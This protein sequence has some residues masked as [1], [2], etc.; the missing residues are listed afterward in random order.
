MK[1]KDAIEIAKDCGLETV[2]EAI[3]NIKI[4][5]GNLFLHGEEQKEYDELLVDY[6]KSD[7]E[8]ETEIKDVVID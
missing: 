6:W 5:A 4:H 1:L 8:L 3:Y 7:Y 2:G